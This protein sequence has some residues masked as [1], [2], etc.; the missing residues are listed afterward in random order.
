MF[1]EISHRAVQLTVHSQGLQAKLHP[2]AA[3]TA[4]L[5]SAI[6]S[7]SIQVAFGSRDGLRLAC[8][9]WSSGGRESTYGW[10]CQQHSCP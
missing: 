4:L 5:R 7:K 10:I 8:V 3:E 6:F 1:G 2:Q 9:K